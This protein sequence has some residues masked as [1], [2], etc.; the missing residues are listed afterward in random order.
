[1]K[2]KK[3]KSLCA[4]CVNMPAKVSKKV[5]GMI[6]RSRKSIMKDGVIT[7][8]NDFTLSFISLPR[9]R[10]SLLGPPRVHPLHPDTQHTCVRLRHAL[11]F[12]SSRVIFVYCCMIGTQ[13][14]F[15]HLQT[16]PSYGPPAPRHE[17]FLRVAKIKL[18]CQYL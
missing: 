13:K 18:K 11:A 1:M 14:C 16:R 10:P 15:I 4:Q 3:R 7:V 6:I 12:I 9:Q 5:V 17:Q 8:P 2:L